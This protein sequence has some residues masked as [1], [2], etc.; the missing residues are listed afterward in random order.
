MI[1]GSGTVLWIGFFQKADNSVWFDILINL[2]EKKGGVDL[3]INIIT[4]KEASVIY[5]F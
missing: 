2:L 1:S 4:G 5:I 3:A